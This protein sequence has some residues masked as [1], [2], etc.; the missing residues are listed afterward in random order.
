[1]TQLVTLVLSLAAFASAEA[2]NEQVLAVVN[3]RELTNRDLDAWFAIRG[4]RGPV[5]PSI[6]EQAAKEL[7]DRELIRQFL[8]RRKTV[9]DAESL[10]AA[11]RVAKSKL[12]GDA[13][14]V[15]AALK[16]LGLDEKRVADDV[17]LT[18]AWNHH[19]RRTV[20]DAQ[21][22]EHW[23]RH[24]RRLD[25]TR[26]R[27]SQ[28]FRKYEPGESVQHAPKTTAALTTIRKDIAA[29]KT[30]FADAAK[31]SSQAPTAAAGGDVGIIGPRG[32]LPVAVSEAAY[33]LGLNELSDVVLSPYGAHL[34]TVTEIKAGDLS[35]ED[36]RPTI[37]K[38]LADRV[39]N[40]TVAAERKT[41]KI[42]EP[43]N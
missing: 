21:I 17:A 6:R 11:M 28:I 3:G 10:A 30:S 22:R 20:S 13:E 41:A 24:R 43:R 42:V 31:S 14:D 39:W 19:A 27:V 9:A 34:V 32:D 36:A 18:L 37:F 16:S 12:A 2:G 26:L 25:G 8:E 15:E 5:S 23:E 35:L 1:M 29:G 33:D 40:E 7:V 4:L 38:E